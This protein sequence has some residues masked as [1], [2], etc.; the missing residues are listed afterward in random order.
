[1]V[2]LAHHPES[3]WK[4]LRGPVRD[5]PLAL[6]DRSTVDLAKDVK[7]TDLV[8]AKY[9]VENFQLHYSRYHKW[10]YLSD[11]QPWEAWIF[12]QSDSADAKR[13][14]IQKQ[15]M[16]KLSIL[17]SPISGVP[18]SSF[19]LHKWGEIKELRESIEVRALVY[20]DKIPEE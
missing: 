10:Y 18:H 6:C 8:F 12:L 19:P 14:G 17:L 4:P 20:Y 9:A 16:V 1:M 3:I 11:Q 13:S 5:W 2:A 7:A 15:D